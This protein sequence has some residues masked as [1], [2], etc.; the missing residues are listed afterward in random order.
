MEF[1]KRNK[2]ERGKEEEIERVVKE[3]LINSSWFI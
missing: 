2:G 1:V 3:C